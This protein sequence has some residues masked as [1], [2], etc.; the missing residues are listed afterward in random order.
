MRPQP[1]PQ[2]PPIVDLAARPDLIEATARL[3]HES[4]QGRTEA[5]P[6]LESAR[7]EVRVSLEPGKISRVMLDAA[8]DVIGWIGGL[9]HYDGRVWELHPIAVAERCRGTG[10]GRELVADLERLV[11]ERGALTLWLGADDENDETSLSGVDL[12]AD[13]AGCIGKVASRRPHPYGFYV[14]MGF[15]IV[16]VMPDANGRGRPDIYLAKRVGAWG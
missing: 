6:D 3:L 10:H 16:G 4:F 8:G 14:K 7:Q 15:R 2:R 1:P 9:P 12:Y 5:W 11:R 13:F